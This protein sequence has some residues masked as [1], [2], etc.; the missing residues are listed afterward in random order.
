FHEAAIPS[1]ARSLRDP[2]ASNH[3]NVSGTVTLLNA[4]QEAGVRRLVYAGSSS[5]YGDTPELPKVETMPSNPRSPYAVSK[6]AGELYCRVFASLFPIETVCLRYFNVFGP[7][8]DPK[9]PYAA[10]IPKFI[11]AL[12]E[13]R[14]VAIEG[15]GTQSRDFTFVANVVQANLKAMAAPGVS[16]QMM[17]VGCG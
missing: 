10:V 3:A 13:G 15:D 7:R 2:V 1:V 6:L 14:P 4:A 16:G 9:S 8:Q 11:L 12:A 5:A 17:N